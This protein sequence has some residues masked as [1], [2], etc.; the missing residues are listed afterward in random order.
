MAKE[1]YPWGPVLAECIRPLVTLAFAG[2]FIYLALSGRLSTDFVQGA[3]LGPITYW[4][5][6]RATLSSSQIPH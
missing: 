5:A 3:I 1:T 4:Y 2:T 6:E